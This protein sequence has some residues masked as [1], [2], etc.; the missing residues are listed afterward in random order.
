[1]KTQVYQQKVLKV[2]KYHPIWGKYSNIRMGAE[3]MRRAMEGKQQE[4]ELLET[5]ILGYIQNHG[6]YTFLVENI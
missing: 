1:M 6:K 2:L 3:S 5:K 4:G